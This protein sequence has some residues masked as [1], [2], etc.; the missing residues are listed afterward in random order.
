MFAV[1]AVH[2]CLETKWKREQGRILRSMATQATPA[3][4]AVARLL[5]VEQVADHIGCSAKSV[6]RYAATGVLPAV[7]LVPGARLR[8]RESDVRAL[9][10]GA[11]TKE[12]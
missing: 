9:I 4:P 8:F 2:S 3:A 7:R 10:N 6:R 1:R 5:S 11:T 12:E